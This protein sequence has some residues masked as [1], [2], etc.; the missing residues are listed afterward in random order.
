ML[1][2][3]LML[4]QASPE[5]GATA[6]ANRVLDEITRSGDLMIVGSG[7]DAAG[8][9][10]QILE[11]QVNG[12]IIAFKTEI[13]ATYFSARVIELGEGSLI[14]SVPVNEIRLRSAPELKSE[15]VL[16]V[17]HRSFDIVLQALMNTRSSCQIEEGIF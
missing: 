6:D 14:E 1:A 13:G 3:M 5:T 16:R 12:C 2:L 10:T 15:L 7:D 8:S 17:A 4:A 11:T 9:S